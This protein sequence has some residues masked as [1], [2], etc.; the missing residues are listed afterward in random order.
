VTTQVYSPLASA[1]GPAPWITRGDWDGFFALFVNNLL[2]LMLIAVLCP[3]IAGIPVEHVVRV[4]L[5]GAAVSILFGNLF[6][7]WQARRLMQKTGRSDVTALPYGVAISSLVANIYLIMGP[8]YASTHDWRLAYHVG[9]FACFLRSLLEAGAALFGG[10]IRR[11]TPRAALLS[12]LAGIALVYIALNF[13]L[14]VFQQPGIALVPL[15]ILLVGYTPGIRLPARIPAGLL[16]V[17]VGTAL[18]WTLRWTGY[19]HFNPPRPGPFQWTLPHPVSLLGFVFS[20]TGLK[21]LSVILPITL[22]HMLE[23]LQILESAEAAGDAYDT[24]TSLLI[25]G[26]GGMVAAAFGSCF[27]TTLYIGHPA[28][29]KLGAR[30]GYSVLN[31]AAITLLCLCGGITWIL[32]VVPL[33][34]CMAILMWVG[35]T[36]AAQAFTDVPAS[37]A[38]AAVLG[39]LPL[40]AQWGLGILKDTASAAGF[41]LANL[42]DRFGDELAVRG[43]IGLSQGALVTSMLLTAILVHVIERRFDRAAIWALIAAA[44]SAVGLIHAYRITPS[45]IENVYGWFAAPEFTISYLSVAIMLGI[46]HLNRKSLTRIQG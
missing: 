46:F 4:I 26:C 13:V 35:M 14:E 21:Y 3:S 27:P 34:P 12:P 30:S 44:L 39:M 32:S 41:A 6:Y 43:L 38:I 20:P 8:I 16:A 5:P 2:Q 25:N 18:A 33:Q 31:G 17:A 9:L 15:F 42:I 24:R 22:V 11:H 10:W 23:A 37:H 40:L 45:G 7:A 36:T 19:L 29:K 1:S 28:W